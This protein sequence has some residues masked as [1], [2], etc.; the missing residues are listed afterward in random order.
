M[1]VRNLAYAATTAL[2]ASTALVAPALAQEVELALSHWVGAAHPLQTTGMEPWAQS[3]SEASNGRIRV[4]IFPAQ[5]LG[6][7]ADHYDMARDGIVD[8]AFINPGYQPGRFPLLSIGE[9][10]FLF[11]DARPGSRALHEWY[12]QYAEAEMSDVHVCLVHL[13]DVA[14]FHGRDPILVPEDLRGKN[15][16]PAHATLARLVNLLGGASVQVS[17]G[18]MRELLSRGAADVTASPWGSLF[19]FGVTDFVTH[20]LDMPLYATTFVFAINRDSWSG[21]SDENRAVME[22]HCNPEWS[23][24]ISTPWIDI[25]A[26]GRQRLIDLGGHTFHVPTPEQVQLWRDAAAPLLDEWRAAVTAAGHDAD[27]ALD[28]FR[29]TAGGMGALAN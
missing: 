20:H 11:A 17:A 5:Q 10:P 16:R 24:R 29:E 28:S 19:T 15:I 21:L 22:D 1:T 9:Q 14:T 25:E 26:S 4:N 8:I 13:H 27:G 23:E 6:A 7:A 12:R 18:E 2:A 3:I